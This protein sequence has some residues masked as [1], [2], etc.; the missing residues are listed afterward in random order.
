MR[1]ESAQ[2]LNLVQE[3]QRVLMVS[4]KDADGDTLGSA[5][6]MCDVIRAMGKTATLRCPPPVPEVYSF[7]PGY[8]IVNQEEGGPPDLILVMDASNLDR[9]SDTLGDLGG[10]PVVNIPD[11]HRRVPAREHHLRG[12]LHRRRVGAPWRRPR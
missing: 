7:L 1:P 6:A 10:Q 3:S 2:I 4:H 11:R 9:L 8:E 12:A 5:L